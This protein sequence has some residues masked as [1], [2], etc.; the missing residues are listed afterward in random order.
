MQSYALLVILSAIFFSAYVI[1]D[2]KPKSFCLFVKRS[3]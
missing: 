3:K 2:L 1:D